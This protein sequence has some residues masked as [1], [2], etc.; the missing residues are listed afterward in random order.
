[1][2]SFRRPVLNGCTKCVKVLWNFCRESVREAREN[3]FISRTKNLRLKRDLDFEK[4]Q[5]NV[6][7]SIQTSG[8]SRPSDKGG[9]SSRPFGAKFGLKIRRGP[10]PPRFLP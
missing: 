7:F 8:G 6:T 3:Y 1:M 2:P 10:G 5:I 4:R 9:R